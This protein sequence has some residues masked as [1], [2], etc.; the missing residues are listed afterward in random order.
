M[1]PTSAPLTAAQLSLVEELVAWRAK[2]KDIVWVVR[3]PAAAG[4][5]RRLYG[6]H[7]VRP[8]NGV[9]GSATSRCLTQVERKAYVSM[10]AAYE[11][12][13][14][15]GVPRREAMLATYR[16]QWRAQG[17]AQG[18]RLNASTWIS[19]TRDLDCGNCE[20]VRCGACGGQRLEE[21]AAPREAVRCIWCGALLPAHTF[22]AQAR[23]TA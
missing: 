6:A 9:A 12:A 16:N 5:A 19:L 18:P 20:L 4:H 15:R 10:A 21:R 1:P 2:V 14:E 8:P 11:L 22:A 23:K 13:L 3:C 17:A 7:G